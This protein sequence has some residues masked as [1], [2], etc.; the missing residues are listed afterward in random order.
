M[1]EEADPFRAAL[2]RQNKIKL[3]SLILQP[4]MR[5]AI[6][7][8][9]ERYPMDDLMRLSITHA[10]NRVCRSGGNPLSAE[11]TYQAVCRL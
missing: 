5:Y 10:Q 7:Y 6:Y 1:E 9:I 4:L 11:P 3:V 8:R 2:S